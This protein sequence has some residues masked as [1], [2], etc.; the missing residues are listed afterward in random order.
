MISNKYIFEVKIKAADGNLYSFFT[1]SVN[2]LDVHYN[3]DD[4][5]YNGQPFEIVEVERKDKIVEGY[6]SNLEL[7]PDYK[8]VKD[9]SEED[10]IVL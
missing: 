6:T 4:K 8:P 10:E 5:V 9:N 1:V 2:I 3:F 7:N